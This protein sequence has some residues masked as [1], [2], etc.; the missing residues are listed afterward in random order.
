MLIATMHAGDSM[1]TLHHRDGREITDKTRPIESQKP[2]YV[3]TFTD[4]PTGTIYFIE[5]A[6]ENEAYQAFAAWIACDE[7]DGRW[8]VEA[9]EKLKQSAIAETK[10][11]MP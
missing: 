8:F 3:L 4:M 9:V 6:G 11:F 1:V 2:A 5:Y 10:L 7:P